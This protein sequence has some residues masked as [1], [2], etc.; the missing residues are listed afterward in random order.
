MRVQI[1]RDVFGDKI[2]R[3]IA[4]NDRCVGN[5]KALRENIGQVDFLFRIR[6]TRPQ[7]LL[8]RIHDNARGMNIGVLD[9][10][11]ESMPKQGEQPVIDSGKIDID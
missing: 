1:D 11:R 4:D 7:R 3:T 10:A 6:R 5:V 2:V 9:R 8:L